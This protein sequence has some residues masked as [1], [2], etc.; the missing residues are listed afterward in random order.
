MKKKF[1]KCWFVALCGVMLSFTPALQPKAAYSQTTEYGVYQVLANSNLRSAPSQD[2]AWLA[3]LPAN[4]YVIMLDAP[5]SEFCHIS[6][7]GLE[8]YI[9]R[10]CIRKVE[11]EAIIAEVLGVT[12]Q[13]TQESGNQVI[14]M[15]DTVREY[16]EGQR[17]LA[18]P[19][20]VA[21]NGAAN[22]DMA[23]NANGA[24]NVSTVENVADANRISEEDAV[25]TSSSGFREISISTSG[26]FLSN[27]SNETPAMEPVYENA[28]IVAN[29]VMR[30]LPSQSSSK[31]TTILRDEMVAIMDEGE[32]GYLHVQY[33]GREGY[34]YATV[35]SREGRSSRN[36]S[37]VVNTIVAQTGQ[38]TGSAAL[39]ARRIVTNMITANAVIH[40]EENANIS[41]QTDTLV[42]SGETTS[43]STLANDVEYQIRTRANMRGTPNVNGQWLATLPTGANVEVL[44]DTQGG[45]TLVQYNGIQGYVLESVVVDSIDVASTGSV[46]YTLTAYCACPKCVGNYS[47]EIT[48]HE[49]HTATGTV[50]QQGRTIAVDPSVIPY[51]TVVHIEGLGDYVAEDCGGMIRGNHID[52]YF[53]NHEEAVAF[54]RQRRYVTF[55]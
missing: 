23:G 32:N 27:I 19:N 18:D 22:A 9:Y 12:I 5:T 51:G 16:M 53:D 48:G 13:E 41:V 29:A 43:A 40:T 25:E 30:E 50:P 17:M 37:G 20:L 46:L 49:A 33:N 24:A 4:A 14:A 31:M 8:G 42:A 11:D 15:P 28:Q 10:G 26:V 52:V 55:N 34:V 54:G 35:V 36:T 39:D 38:S 7:D 45:Y 2:G 21:A 6:Y 1:L 3:C 47:P 44:G